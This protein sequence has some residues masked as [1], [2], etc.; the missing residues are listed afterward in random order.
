MHI[1]Y[2]NPAEPFVTAVNHIADIDGRR[3]EIPEGF[4]NDLASIPAIGRPL[5]KK[6]GRHSWA[7]LVHDWLYD[8]QIGTRKEADKIFLDIMKKHGV[9]WWKRSAMYRAV[10]VGG[11]YAWRT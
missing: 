11:W 9:S 3:I 7:A 5:I 6:V 8:Q 1:D 2:T 4:T 10:R